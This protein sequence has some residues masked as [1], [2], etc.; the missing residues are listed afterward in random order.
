[1]KWRTMNTTQWKM[2]IIAI[3]SDGSMISKIDEYAT[4]QEIIFTKKLRYI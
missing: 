1:M 3:I 4:I 2:R